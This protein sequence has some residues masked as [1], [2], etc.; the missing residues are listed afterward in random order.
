MATVM[1]VCVSEKRG[2]PKTSIPNGQ[3]IAGYGLAS[4]AHGGSWHRQVSLLAWEKIQDFNARGAQVQDGAFGENL[5]VKGLELN[6][7]PIG[8]RLQVGDA[9]LTVTQ[10]GKEC[11][12]HCEIFKRMGECIMPV[13]GIFAR[14]LKGGWIKKGDQVSVACLP[15][16]GKGRPFRAAVI[17][18]SDQ[19]ARGLR[20]DE[21]GP[22]AAEM[23]RKAGYQVVEELLLPDSQ[24]QLELELKRIAD[25]HLADLILTTGGTGF[26]PRDHTPEASINVIQRPAPGLSEAM[27]M[28]AMT[29]SPRSILSRGVSGVREKTLILNLPGS[30]RAVKECLLFILPVLEH[31][32]CTLLDIEEDCAAAFDPS[33]GTG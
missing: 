18:L 20:P 8:A 33:Q 2:T 24:A 11:H 5:I 19:G 7:L 6:S 16:C 4:D 31:G 17:T 25:H 30:P 29:S 28:N 32:L 27:R 3:L 1:A 10:I 26:S 12:S 21:S 9:L 14:V 23:A 15:S 13:Y 22:A